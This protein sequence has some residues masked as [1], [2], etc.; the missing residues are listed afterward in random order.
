LDG[1]IHAV[2]SGKHT[3]FRWSGNEFLQEIVNEPEEDV[4]YRINSVSSV[5]D[6][7]LCD[8]ELKIGG[9]RKLTYKELVV[10][11]STGFVSI[12]ED[13]DVSQIYADGKMIADNFYYGRPWRVPARLLAGKKCYLVMSERKDDFY[14]EF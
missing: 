7:E 4:E 1:S 14:C 10:K 6:L 3:Y 11:G 8:D 12:D 5:P 9:E 2:E 13:C